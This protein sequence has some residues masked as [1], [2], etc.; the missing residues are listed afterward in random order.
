MPPIQQES[1]CRQCS[2]F[3]SSLNHAVVVIC[4]SKPAVFSFSFAQVQPDTS[5]T[6]LLAQFQLPDDESSSSHTHVG[7]GGNSADVLAHT[8]AMVGAKEGTKEGPMVGAKEGGNE[9]AEEGAKKGTFILTGLHTC[10]DLAATMLRVFV[11]SKKAVGLASVG[12]C[13][14]KLTDLA[15]DREEMEEGG[16]E[17]EKGEEKRGEKEGEKRGEKEGEK[18]EE[19]GGEKRGKKREREKEGEKGEERGGE[20]RGKKRER[21]MEGEKEGVAGYPMSR[22]LRGLNTHTLSYAAKELACHSNA[23]L[24]ERFHGECYIIRTS[25]NYF[26]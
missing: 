11:Q 20:K 12:C 3:P 23:A 24:H 5:V 15:L 7:V 17:R 10:G 2:L 13:Y 6:K 22:F 18:G 4:H 16:E 9:G 8:G 1:Q 25:C 19:K 21:E 26:S 14:M